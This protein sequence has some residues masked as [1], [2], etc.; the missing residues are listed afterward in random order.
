MKC[1]SSKQL[2]LKVKADQKPAAKWLAMQQA[3]LVAPQVVM[4]R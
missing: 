2:E 1:C 4:L 3:Q